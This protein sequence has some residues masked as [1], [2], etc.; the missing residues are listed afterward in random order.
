VNFRSRVRLEPVGFQLT[1]MIDCIFLMLCFFLTSQVFSQW[2]SEID[3]TLPTA[4]TSQT[5]QR[6]PGE[7]I[8]N[9][10]KLG[11]TLVNGRVLADDA[12]GNMLR[13][14]AKLFPGQPV[15]IRADKATDYEHVVRVL[16]LCR[17][18]DIWNISFATSIPDA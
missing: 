3:I 12:L 10:D 14:V 7:I 4:K 5:P 17:L 1:P 9:I 16:D 13:Q 18:A 6:L 2:E 8:V 11:V 15:L